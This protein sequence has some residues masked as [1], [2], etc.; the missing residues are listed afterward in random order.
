MMEHSIPVDPAEGVGAEAVALGLQKVQG[1]GRI[2]QPV[3][4]AQT[5]GK[6]RDCHAALGG[7]GYNVTPVRLILC[8]GG[9]KIGR[10]QQILQCGTGA[11]GLGQTVQEFGTDD[12]ASAEE[13]GDAA[14]IQ[15]PVVVLAGLAEQFEALSIRKF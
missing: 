11:V 6:G 15:V 5:G 14:Q 10:E 2:T 13:Q 12:A 9:G 4:V 8:Q 1:T 7:S 3:V